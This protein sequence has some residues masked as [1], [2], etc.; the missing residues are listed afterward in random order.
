MK[1]KTKKLI[2]LIIVITMIV[3]LI[4]GVAITAF[5]APK[6]DSPGSQVGQTSILYD[7]NNGLL[8]PEA[9]VIV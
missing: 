5:A 6:G 8:T 1:K 9:N 2:A 4:A 3:S 7:N